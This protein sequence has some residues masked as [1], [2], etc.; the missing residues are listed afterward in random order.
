MNNPF[1]FR[2]LSYLT[3]KKESQG[4]TLIELLVALIIIG[5]LAAVALPNL[6]GQVGKAREAEGKNGIGALNRAQ[7]AYHLEKK[8]FAGNMNTSTTREPEFNLGSPN[9]V[10][11][12][13]LNSRYYDFTFDRL[14][15]SGGTGLPYG[16]FVSNYA[17]P[18]NGVNNGIRGFGGS[19]AYNRGRY[20]AIVCV[21]DD[22]GIAV[23]VQLYL[24]PS[25]TSSYN[26]L[27][28]G[29]LIK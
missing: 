12:L 23:V 19:V 21:S 4:F 27:P 18:I 22:I 25:G 24:A 15:V 14:D 6:L 3:A 1:K 8:R 5:V 16:E 13:V 17:F 9:N 20:G 29:T 28:Q 2:L 26:C 7:Q 10:L 11:G